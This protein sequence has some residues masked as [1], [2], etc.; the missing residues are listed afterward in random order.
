MYWLGSKNSVTRGSQGPN[1]KVNSDSNKK[2][3]NS[4]VTVSLVIDLNVN[5][6]L[7]RSLSG[8]LSFVFSAC[9]SS[10]FPNKWEPVLGF[11]KLKLHYVFI[12]SQSCLI[13]NQ[14]VH[15]F[16]M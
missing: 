2:V 15:Y 1:P 11:F 12:T 16:I 4:R 13:K 5:T 8:L 7:Q 6:G 14:A 9:V 3:W 10:P